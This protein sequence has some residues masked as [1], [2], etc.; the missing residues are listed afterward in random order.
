VDTRLLLHR[1]IR[2]INRKKK[3]LLEK[4]EYNF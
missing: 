1:I 2:I 4:N 3:S